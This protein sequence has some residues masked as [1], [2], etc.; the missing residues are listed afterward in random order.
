MMI[1]MGIM[2]VVLGILAMAAPLATGMAV[3]MIVGS[4]V[5]LGGILQVVLGVKAE[6]WGS[7]I[8]GIILGI[9]A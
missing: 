5:V 2:M 9:V 1:L 6:S 8:F 7:R 4:L 3:A